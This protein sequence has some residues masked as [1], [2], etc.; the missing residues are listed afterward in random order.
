MIRKGIFYM[1]FLMLNKLRQHI[2]MKYHKIRI[3]FILIFICGFNAHILSQDTSA[4]FLDAFN[5]FIDHAVMKKD[6]AALDSVYA[7]D[8]MFTHGTGLIDHK[9]SWIKAVMDE[10]STYLS[11]E[12]DSTIVERHGNIAMI[13][14]KLTIVRKGEDATTKYAIK[15]VRVFLASGNRWQMISHRSVQ[16]W[17][18]LPL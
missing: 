7:D 1:I 15:Y 18:N 17:N 16:Q 2:S 9:A 4:V 8:F 14:G 13:Y 3:C 12:H 5:R 10:K 11:R 6:K